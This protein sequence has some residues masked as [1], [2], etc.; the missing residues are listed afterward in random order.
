MLDETPQEMCDGERIIRAFC[1][2]FT[3][4]LR[5]VRTERVNNIRFADAWT[6]S[7]WDQSRGIGIQATVFEGQIHAY[8]EAAGTGDIA[9]DAGRVI[10][11]ALSLMRISPAGNDNEDKP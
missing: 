4:P 10:A 7:L 3:P 9:A 5:Y 11:R 2:Q 6:T 8:I 1:E